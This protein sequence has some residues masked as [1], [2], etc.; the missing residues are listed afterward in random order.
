MYL[1]YTFDLV[2]LNISKWWHC[3]KT[4]RELGL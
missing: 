2:Q 3:R 1:A 4:V